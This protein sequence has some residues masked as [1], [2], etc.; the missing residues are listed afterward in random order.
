MISSDDI[1]LVGLVSGF[2]TIVAAMSTLAPP[3]Q[4]T[5]PENQRRIEYIT[6]LANQKNFEFTPVSI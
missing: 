5:C 6:N 3:V 1:N 4:V 2:Q